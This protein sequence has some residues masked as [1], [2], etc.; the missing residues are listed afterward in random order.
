MATDELAR[1]YAQA[2]F[3]QAAGRWQK[4]LRAVNEALE[5]TGVETTLD[6]PVEKFDRKR[7]LL[8]R[9]LPANIDPEVRNFVYLLAS[10]NE[11][12]L[13]PQVLVEFDRFVARGPARELAIVSSAIPL[14]EAER[15]KLEQKVH[16]QFG[17]DI[18]FEYRVDSSLLGGLVVRV[19]DRVI[20][21][22]VAGKLNAMR[23][24]LEAT[25]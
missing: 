7:E 2:I 25:R 19:G 17:Q 5:R 8:N 9:T 11:T 20:D 14:T 10:K 21:G 4:A 23:Q 6:N 22:S 24:K 12:H 13:L 18:D 15:Q 3:E 16:A 1:T